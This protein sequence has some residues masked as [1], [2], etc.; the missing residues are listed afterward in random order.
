MLVKSLILTTALISSTGFAE[1]TAATT[2]TTPLQVC[3]QLVEAAKADNFTTAAGLMLAPKGGKHHAKGS[4]KFHKMG[5][6]YLKEIKTITCATEQI[7][8]TRAFVTAETGA[9]KRLIPFVQ[10]GGQWKFDMKTYKSFY[11]T[12]KKHG[13][14]KDM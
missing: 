12:G 10:D 7:A 4:P 5:A 1:D 2:G 9:E 6:D 8:G 11:A 14:N 3:G 13:K